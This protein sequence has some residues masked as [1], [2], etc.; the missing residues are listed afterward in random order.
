MPRLCSASIQFRPSSWYSRMLPWLIIF[1][2]TVS[3]ASFAGSD[4]SAAT[5][6]CARGK[7]ERLVGAAAARA[8][9]PRRG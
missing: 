9:A 2:C 4:A 6:V 7:G 3:R 1:G 8:H 5:S